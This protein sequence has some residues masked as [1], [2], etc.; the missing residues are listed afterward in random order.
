MKSR[1]RRVFGIT[2]LFIGLKGYKFL[3]GNFKCS[4]DFDL[5]M[6]NDGL[7]F[8]LLY[9]GLNIYWY[10]PK[11]LAEFPLLKLKQSSISELL[12]EIR[13]VYFFMGVCFNFSSFN[14]RYFGVLGTP[15]V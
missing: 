7:D 4:T 13:V 15:R 14:L 10:F 12:A 6:T 3:K 9:L 8:K 5:L 11:S 2:K 1:P